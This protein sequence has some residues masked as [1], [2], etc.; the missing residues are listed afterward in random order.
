MYVE[1]AVALPLFRTFTYRVP[2]GMESRAV[3]GARVLVPF[4]R[5][6]RIGWI[7]AVKETA[8][9]VRVR[10]V[11]DIPDDEPAVPESLLRL[12]RW[13]ADYYIAP[14][15]LVLRTALPAALNT[16]RL[17]S[18]SRTR[19]VLTLTRDLPTLAERDEM[20][21]R[22]PRQRELWD[23]VESMGGGSEVAH[24]AG[25][26]GFAYPVIN[27][28]VEKGIARIEEREDWRDPYE[29]VPIVDAP[30]LQP[31]TPQAR[32]IRA[33]IDASRTDDPGVFLLRG[34]TGSGK[35]L[36]Y[37]EL[38]REV[39]DVQG[40]T[41]IVLVPEIALTP[42]TVGRFRSVFGDRVAVLHSA[43][44]D[45]ERYDEWR[46]LRTGAKR[47]VVGARSAIFAPL[48]ELGAIVID[49]EHEGTYKQAEA[50]RYHAR[51]AAV[52]RARMEGAVCVLGSAT[53]SLESWS[54]AANG[55]YRLLEL[56]E[57][58]QGLPMPP[59]TV[60]DLRAERKRQR[61]AL[62]SLP[63]ESVGILSDA[64]VDAVQARLG[65]GEQTILLLNRRGYSS[66]VQCRDCG[67]VW[68]CPDCNVSLTYHRRRA[69]LTCHYCFYEEPPPDRCPA[70][71]QADLGF[72][73]VGTEQVERAV[74]D[75][76]P[77]ARLARMDVD[78][79]SGKWAHH[80]ILG[81]VE[82]GEVD[83]LLGTQMI[84]K[85]LDFPNVTLVG[86]INADV[87]INLP[88]FRATERTFQLLTQVAGRAGR[89]PKGGEVI[90]QTSLPTHYA[91]TRATTHDFHGF[92]EDELLNRQSPPYPPHSRLVN[93]L[94]SATDEIATQEA[95]ESAAD[96]LRGLITERDLAEVEMV[97]PAPCA[98]D[99]IRTR[100]RWHLLLRS[101][102]G[103]LLGRVARYFAEKF[104]LPAGKHDLRVMVDRDPVSLL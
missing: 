6:E 102:N 52:M 56:P 4:A 84:A 15:G 16:P 93:V 41:A 62:T 88:D 60:V 9:V 61:E 68:H 79:T 86:V 32:A 91:V 53:P 22:S 71:G 80:H 47:I 29:R 10:D 8:D 51:E 94:V 104:D 58:V 19:R 42:Q 83:I 73:G 5:R 13:I 26:L 66:F 99:R 20:F 75:A 100:W 70:C 18:P 11:L 96:W 2:E 35:T 57:R 98:I 50:P 59:I 28:L 49:E 89:G 17:T 55:G 97:G 24:L 40:R 34:V 74:G 12:C 81:R 54:A 46:A 78:T 45:G 63:A 37:I 67:Q 90:I 43:L 72:R 30:R 31:T 14:L 36:V 85:G 21:A 38:L 39:V 103:P 44:S 1:V 64:L 77:S 3:P 23:V 87:G 76:F 25:R 33:M 7:D 82:R 95:A 92:V 48:P 27:G 69:R 101:E 65:R